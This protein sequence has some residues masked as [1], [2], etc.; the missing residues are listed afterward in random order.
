MLEDF[1]SKSLVCEKID[2]SIYWSNQ[3][4]KNMAELRAF[5]KGRRCEHC[6]YWEPYRR[7]QRRWVWGFCRR[8][9]HPVCKWT[10]GEDCEW[11]EKRTSDLLIVH[12]GMS[13]RTMQYLRKYSFDRMWIQRRFRDIHFWNDLRGEG[14]FMTRQTAEI[15][16]RL[17]ESIGRS[18]MLAWQGFN[19]KS[20]SITP[21]W[22]DGRTGVGSSWRNRA[23]KYGVNRW[24]VWDYEFKKDKLFGRPVRSAHN[25]SQWAAYS[26]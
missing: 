17:A 9:C 6:Q 14:F 11:F 26:Q 5:L 13:R 25:L 15:F 3:I 21:R 20:E 12:G 18:Y 1:W 8:D 10:A 23:C 7:S 4:F 22:W 16:Q 19:D 24:R 2:I